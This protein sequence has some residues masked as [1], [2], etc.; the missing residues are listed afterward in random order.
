[1][2][3]NAII[4]VLSIVS[5]LAMADSYVQRMRVQ[6]QMRLAKENERLLLE[7][8]LLASQARAEAEHQRMLA[9]TNERLA[10]EQKEVALRAAGKA[11]SGN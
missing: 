2:K 7:T 10:N 9:L 8:Q 4:V 3:K 6:E 1:M 11:Q 5:L